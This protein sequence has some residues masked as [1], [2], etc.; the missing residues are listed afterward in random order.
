MTV[1]DLAPGA[2]VVLDGV[3]WAVE[4]AEPHLGHVALTSVEGERMRVNLRF[5]INHP[6]CRQS[7]RSSGEPASARGRQPATEWDLT[8]RQRELTR[9]RVAHLLEVE[10][11]FRSGDRLR[12]R[13]DEPK[14]CYDPAATTL[15]QRRRAKVAELT[16]LDP[17]QARLLGLDKI[18][19]RTLIRWEARRRRFGAIGCADHRWL[20]P[21][22]GHPSIS[23]KVKEAIYAVHA[24]SL[25]RSR[26]SMRTKERLIHQYVR[27]QYGPEAVAEIPSYWTL[28]AVWR[29]WFGPGGG[30]Q[31][32][33]R[34]AALPTTGEHVV[35]HRPGQVV[36]LD[37]TIL[38]V[39]VRDTVF[40]DPV[41]VHLTIALDVY[42]HSL[43]RSG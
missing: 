11:G 32:S 15:T 6:D 38:P 4:R 24:E 42:S 34:S 43:P 2:A 10:T 8:P 5:L 14:P 40:D 20:R 35:I 28:R 18:S 25:H 16:A 17:D 26:V 13:A 12:A 21:A 23:E 29:E 19:Y 3:E 1:L 9:L 37:T 41:S 27:E 7:T 33:V 22:G 36:A 30:C 39:K 31:R